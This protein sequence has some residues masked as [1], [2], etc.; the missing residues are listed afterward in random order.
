MCIFVITKQLVKPH[1]QTTI[2][3]NFLALVLLLCCTHFSFAQNKVNGVSFAQGVTL[4]GTL[5]DT[6]AKIQLANSAVSLLRTKDSV[7]VKFVRADKDGKFEIKDINPADYILWITYPKY[8]EYADIIDLHTDND[9]GQVA[10]LTK[11]VALQN[12]IVR[13]GGAIRMKGD[14]LAF[15]ADSFKVKEGATVEDL[16][17][18]LPGLQVNKKGEITAQGEKVEKVLVDGEEFFGDDP[19][20]ATQNLNANTVKEVQ[21]F[22]KKSDQANFTGVDDGQ[23][24]KTI[25]LKLKD[26]AKK[27]YFGKVNLAGG[28]PNRWDNKVLI[29]S[30]KK[31]RKLSAFALM[32]NTGNTRLGWDEEAQYGGGNNMEMSDDGGMYISNGDNFTPYQVSGI[33]ST[34]QAGVNYSN[35]Y[36]DAKN[37]LNGAYRYQKLNTE[38]STSNYTQNILKDSQYFSN[39]RGY[40]FNSKFRHKLN[41]SYDMQLD[42]SQSFKVT[43]VGSTGQTTNISKT[44]SEALDSGYAPVNKNDRRTNSLATN[45][46]F[47]STLIY[48][49][50]L[51]KKGRT[52][53][54]SFNQNYT[55]T[56]S[57]GFLYS[58]TDFYK[59]NQLIKIDTV[60]QKKSN[61]NSYLG[62]DG[63]LAYTEPIGKKSI[64]EVSYAL[65][66]SNSENKVLSYDKRDGKYDKLNSIFSNDYKFNIQKHTVGLGYRFNEKKYNF[67][68]GSDLSNSDW[69]QLNVFKDSTRNY[70]FRN[71]FPRAN[72]QYK[73]GQYS[74]I[75]F[76]YN[77]RSQ[78]PSLNQLQP[79]QDNSN[80]NNIAIGNPNLKQSFSNNFNLS[81]NFYQVL[82]ERGIWSYL[83]FNPT[84]NAFS[85]YDTTSAGVRT[86]K[87]VNVDGNYRL[88]GY[89][90]YNFKLK[91]QNLQLSFSLNPSVSRQYNYVNGVFN[92]N[93]NY[94]YTGG[95][96]L[97]RYVEKKYNI[98]MQNE[99]TYNL[100]KSSIN[101]N[102]NIKYYSGNTN[103]DI[104]VD[105]PWKIEFNTDANYE[106]RQ[107][108]SSFDNNTNRLLW[109]ARIEKKLLKNEFRLGFKVNDILNQNNGFNRYVTSNYVSQS[110]NEVLRR[111][112]LV[113]FTWNFNKGPQ[114]SAS[115]E[116]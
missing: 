70:S 112:W 65:G 11:A 64:V 92:K 66:I 74:R 87:S 76:N 81:Y 82:K 57:D 19:T 102:S 94:Q 63:K 36:N 22:D 110:N 12:V 86:F 55:N 60:D 105:L 7:L 1:N 77:G 15:M 20:L 104:G 100:N 79:V 116:D 24:T 85:T 113:T 83:F 8:A 45:K 62:F 42:S 111:Y 37:T 27:G 32:S 97:S 93:N 28:L 54:A 30:F 21:V 17:K 72:F 49:K 98:S 2:M 13:G 59:G 67:G 56:E 50:K 99:L 41:G 35:K 115:A 106:W 88:G 10:M 26:D 9:M 109:N 3:R 52:F 78:A 73:L 47:S 39:D 96:N 43:F 4:K 53:S 107:K 48:R 34:W 90:D 33:P 61:A 14:T 58:L 29:N 6:S 69:K 114:K 18:I 91:K 89:F 108:T 68:F 46:A 38:G 95:I 80:T 103:L 44:Y 75:S 23:K 25:N 16:L 40:N 71:I 31:N 84:N 51:K 5:R 101:Q